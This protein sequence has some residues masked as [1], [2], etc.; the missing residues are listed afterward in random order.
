MR[1][2]LCLC[3]AAASASAYEATGLQ[4]F[5][6]VGYKKITL[7]KEGTNEKSGSIGYKGPRLDSQWKSFSFAFIPQDD[8]EVGIRF[9]PEGR[10]DIPFEYEAISVNG[11]PLDGASWT[12]YP[13]NVEGARQGA[14]I[15]EPGQPLR[16]RAY[17]QNSVLRFIKVKKGERV[18]ISMRGRSGS[19]LDALSGRLEDVRLNLAEAIKIG[20]PSRGDAKLKAMAE[21]LDGLIALS[22]GK[23]GISVAPMGKDEV[24]LRT[25]KAKTEELIAAYEAEK[26]RTANEATPC[27]YDQPQ[28][29]DEL[30]KAIYPVVQRSSQLQ[31]ACLLEF[32]LKP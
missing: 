22:A 17:F 30:R 25:L 7:A 23:L 32:M 4:A 13:P 24:T 15:S 5:I 19:F 11:V 16:I 27:L 31:T 18:E 2:L 12:L 21:N 8:G 28:E 6:E 3:L 26:A 20:E 10:G 1:I 29:R 14:I 9:G